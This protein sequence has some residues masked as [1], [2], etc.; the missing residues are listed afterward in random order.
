MYFCP[1]TF[2]GYT[3]LASAA[4]YEDSLF[5]LNLSSSDEEVYL[6]MNTVSYKEATI[7]ESPL[8]HPDML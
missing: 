1:Y 8:R 5:S 3:R 2:W 7:T 4:T 6:N